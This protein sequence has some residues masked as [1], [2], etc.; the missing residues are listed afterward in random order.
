[1]K[2]L[3]Q[4]LLSLLLLNTFSGCSTS[5]KP[6]TQT[7]PHPNVETSSQKEDVVNVVSGDFAA[8]LAE[9]EGKELDPKDPEQSLAESLDQL[10]VN[11]FTPSGVSVSDAIT[12]PGHLDLWKRQKVEIRWVQLHFP[13]Q[14]MLMHSIIM[15]RKEGKWYDVLS[16]TDKVGGEIHHF[17]FDVTE[18]FSPKAE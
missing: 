3:L 8:V 13:K 10:E 15:K 7:P 9:V 16:T 1:M 5:P 4:G 2:A 6:A 18:S 14:K 17:H 11:S 12:I